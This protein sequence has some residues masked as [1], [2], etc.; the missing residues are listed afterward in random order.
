MDDKEIEKLKENSLK[1]LNVIQ[2][3][4]NTVGSVK[5]AEALMED[6]KRICD[7]YIFCMEGLRTIYDYGFSKED[8]VLMDLVWNLFTKFIQLED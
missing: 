4:Y 3:Y 6:Y 2:K 7:N 1:A 8:E 5:K